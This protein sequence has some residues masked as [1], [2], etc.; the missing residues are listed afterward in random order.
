M[1][2]LDVQQALSLRYRTSLEADNYTDQLRQSLGLDTKAQVARLAIGRSLA[3]G[4]LP[5]ETVDSQGK[6]IPAMSL[7]SPENIGAWVGLLV[8]HSLTCGGTAIDTME[9]L[10]TS[11]RAHWHR[12]AVALWG[13]W[14]SV[15]RNYDKFIEALMRR[16]DMPD[17]AVK[18]SVVAEANPS[19]AADKLAPTDASQALPKALAELGIKV[20]VKGAIHGPRMTRYR[21]LL[22]NLADSAKLKRSMSQLGLA[23]NLG[24]ALPT[25]SNGDEAKTLFI[26]LPRPKNTWKTV[27]IER[28]R[29]WAQVGPKDANQLMVYAGVDVTGEDVAFDL[30]TAPHLLVGGTTGSGKSVCLHSLI[31]SLLQRHKPNTLQLALIDPKQVEFAQYAKLQ[32]LYRG[33]VATELA[34]AREMLQELG[35]EMDARYSMFSRLG[36]SNISEARRKGQSMPF[37][38]LL[39]EE[40]ADLVLQDSGIEP[41]IARL[42]Q[43]ARA[44]GIHLVLATQRPDSETFSGLIRSNI[45][46]RIAL[47]VQK[48]T[49]ST[50]ILDEKGAENL[51]GSGDMLIRMPGEAP[52]RAHGVFVKLENVAQLVAAGA[53]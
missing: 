51:L 45:P 19:D 24:S 11:I 29:E 42:A 37:I 10:R 31:L 50:I 25:V 6:D 44:A 7:F 12:G 2:D 8:S 49:E 33:A 34:Q 9:S 23:L 13:D 27:G 40:L 16:S 30:A 53:R 1:S 18:R 20:Q 47:T 52:R 17:F 41:L 35:V 32:N 36:V 38:V 48:S 4:K 22:V 14:L 26:D 5:E 39:I 15:D 46:G 21:V 28:L 3:M 43:K